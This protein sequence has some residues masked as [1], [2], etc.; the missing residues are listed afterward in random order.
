M[1]LQK[2]NAICGPPFPPT[3]FKTDCWDN[4]Q[5]DIKLYLVFLAECFLEARLP[6][7]VA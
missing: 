1:T 3:S 7:Q 4:E 2:Q 5:V 6:V